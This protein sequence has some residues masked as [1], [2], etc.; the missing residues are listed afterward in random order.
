MEVFRVYATITDK[1]GQKRL[2]CSKKIAATTGW[3]VYESTKKFILSKYK[4]V[5]SVELE[6]WEILNPF[7]AH[8]FDFETLTYKFIIL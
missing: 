5:K 6:Y 3:E 2:F 1:S 4:D 7:V 8:F